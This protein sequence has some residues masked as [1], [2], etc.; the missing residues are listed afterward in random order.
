M[1]IFQSDESMKVVFLLLKTTLV[2]GYSTSTVEN[3]FSARHRVT[4]KGPLISPF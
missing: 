1:E 4:N 2:T 3:S